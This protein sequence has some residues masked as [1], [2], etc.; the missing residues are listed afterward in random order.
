[1]RKVSLIAIG[2]L[3][4]CAN[5]QVQQIQQPIRYSH[6]TATVEQFFKNRYECLKETE[7]RQTQSTTSGYANGYGA[8]YGGSANS[9]VRPTCSALSACLAARGYVKTPNG[10]L[11]VPAGAVIQCSD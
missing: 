6:K 5:Q 7:Q 11:E 10:N 8:N 3:A 2:M 9:T 1:M 4:G